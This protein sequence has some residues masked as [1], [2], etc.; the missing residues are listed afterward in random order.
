MFIL[1]WDKKNDMGSGKNGTIRADNDQYICRVQ[2]WLMNS[3]ASLSLHDFSS[4][5]RQ[6]DSADKVEKFFKFVETIDDKDW[7]PKEFYF[8][9][10]DFQLRFGSNGY[11]L[12]VRNSH[13]RKR[14]VYK[15]KSHSGNRVH[16]FRYSADKDFPKVMQCKY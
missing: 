1:E 15:N 6:L 4:G 9:L 14:D 16:L 7:T 3:C 10:S 13:V 11:K 12:L 2:T 5:I 8:L